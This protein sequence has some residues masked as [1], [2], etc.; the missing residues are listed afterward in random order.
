ML[1]R[2]VVSCATV[3]PR[4]SVSTAAPEL[5]N[6]S[7]SSAMAAAF[8]GFATGPPSENETPEKAPQTKGAPAQGAGLTA[9]LRGMRFTYDP[10]LAARMLRN[11]RS[12]CKGQAD[13]RRSLVGT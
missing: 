4:Y 11:L 12:A 3:R 9:H 6:F 5:R 1:L 2:S 13:N 8:S 10:A 7:V